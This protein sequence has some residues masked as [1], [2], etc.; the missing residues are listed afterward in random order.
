MKCRPQN[1]RRVKSKLL[2]LWEWQNPCRNPFS[3]IRIILFHICFDFLFFFWQLARLWKSFGS[4]M[5]LK[6]QEKNEIESF[7]YLQSFSL[8]IQYILDEK[9]TIQKNRIMNCCFI[10]NKTKMISWTYLSSFQAFIIKK[11][12]ESL[13]SLLNFFCI[14]KEISHICCQAWILC[15]QAQRTSNKSQRQTF[16]NIH[17]LISYCRCRMKEEKSEQE[18]KNTIIIIYQ[19]RKIII[20]CHCDICH[21][22]L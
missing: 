22:E 19:M 15:F 14:E 20:Y 17:T 3:F 5:T 16:T 18:A 9:K 7:N 8:K 10:L 2:K 6:I 4:N 12:C 11:N 13:F 1:V 21:D